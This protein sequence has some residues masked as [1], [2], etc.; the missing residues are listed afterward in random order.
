MSAAAEIIEQPTSTNIVEFN[1]FE[2]QLAEF[3]A[4]YDDVVYDL[5]DPKQEKQA[6]SDKYAIGQV[7]GELDRTHEKVKAPLLAQTRLLDAE[8]KR[9]KDDLQGVQGKIK[10]QIEEHEAKQQAIEDGLVAAVEAIKAIGFFDVNPTS[11]QVMQRLVQI[12]KIT[13]DNTFAHHEGA[14]LIAHRDTLAGLQRLY[15]TVSQAE[16]D[17]A[18]LAQLKAEAA[19]R[20][21]QERDARIALEAAEQAKREA[22]EAKAAAKR[23]AD[24]AIERER[25]AREQA[26]QAARDAQERAEQE[27]RDARARE[28]QARIKAEFDAQRAAERAEREKAEAV[29]LAEHEAQQ[30]A[31]KAERERLA[32][33]ES[34]RVE[35]ERRESDKKHRKSIDDAASKVLSELHSITPSAAKAI[36]VSIANGLV[37]N[38]K[39]HY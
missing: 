19:E 31:E 15:N 14:A 26:E 3:K 38:I 8:R 10:S 23:E 34:M 27:A 29:A 22:E 20:E 28:E 12:K 13:I 4:K 39:I 18:E 37:P 35:Q 32:V 33:I 36:V 6:R 11:D 2:Q 17:A 9:I 1:K 25:L 24:A 21:Q 30:K 16:A 5:S 7:V